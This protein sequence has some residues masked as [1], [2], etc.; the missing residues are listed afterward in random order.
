[1]S[2]TSLPV[3]DIEPLLRMADDAAVAETARRIGEA[4]A[5]FGFFYAGGHGIS[6]GVF[7]DL[8]DASRSFFALPEAEKAR[9]S[10]D[11]GGIAWRGWFPVAGELTSGI[12]DLKKGLY[13]GEELGA[14]DPRVREGLP[15][16]GANLWPDAV[17]A[18]RPAVEAYVGAATRAG[19]AL[20][21]GM[22]LSLGLEADHFA[23][24]LTRRPTLLFRI[25]HYPATDA[26]REEDAFGVGEHSDYGLLT[27]L[28]QD[29]KGGLEV[30]T[31]EGWIDVPPLGDALVINVGDMF[32]RLTR[33][34]FRSAPH[35]VV[36]RAGV[37]R[38]SFP[39]FFDP[40]FV[41]PV[42]PL[43]IEGGTV[44]G[45]ARWDDV[46]LHAEIGTYGDYLLGKVSKVFPQLAGAKLATR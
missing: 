45:D 14:D 27:L 13:L 7:S 33:G 2:S 32:E 22:A 17:P 15:L 29:D 12:P 26:A 38:Y 40:D 1:M 16:H 41:A 10:M 25:F 31:R 35:R 36:N 5:E 9:I 46:D 34:R 44:A 43:P 19:E 37:S 21:R 8:L 3:I 42:E 28:A 18:L 24:G 39:L 20:M 23:D 4:A 30:R 6:A 11:Q